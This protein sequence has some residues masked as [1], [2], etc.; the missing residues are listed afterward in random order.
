[1][2]YFRN[3]SKETAFD[4][5][6]YEL[7]VPAGRILNRSRSFPKLKDGINCVPDNKKRTVHE[8]NLRPPKM[9]WQVIQVQI[10][11]KHTYRC[12]Y[13]T[14]SVPLSAATENELDCSMLSRGHNDGSIDLRPVWLNL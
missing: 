11:H 14:S 1:M 2:Y 3:Q 4:A 5:V 10:F 12:R 7:P 6:T 13:T 8:N 9:K